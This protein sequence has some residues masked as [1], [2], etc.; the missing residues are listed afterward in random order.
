LTL[1]TVR[2][3]PFTADLNSF[4]GSDW[5]PDGGAHR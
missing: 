3:S 4:T 1:F 2:C 5:R